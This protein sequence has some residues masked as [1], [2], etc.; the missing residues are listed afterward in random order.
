M[1]MKRIF[2]ILFLSCLILSNYKLYT[3]ERSGSL[4]HY[5]TAEEKSRKHEIG[6][7]F[8]PTLPPDAPVRNV[9]E[10]E[11][12]QSVLVRYPFGLPISM[13]K[14]MAEDCIV[15]TIVLNQSQENTVRAQYQAAG[16][17]MS[18]CE[19]LWAP[20]D[21]YWTR[22]YGPWYVVNGNNEVGVTN[23]PYN[24][25]RPD[26]DDIPIRI[27][28]YLD[29]ELYGMELIGA[30]GNY[31][32]DGMGIAAST[33]LVVEENPS[34]TV[35]Q[36]ETRVNY[37]LGVH[38]YHILPDP[39]GEYIK[40]I[41]CWG[42]FLDIDKVLIGQVSKNDNRYAD[43][44]YVADYFAQQISS[45]GTP[46]Q[47][48][49][50]YTPGNYPFTPYTNSLILN[51]KVFVPITGSQHDNNALLAYENSMP[52][53]EI[54]GVSYSGWE[55][56]DALHCRAK[57][58]ADI[59]MLYIRHIPLHGYIHQ[60]DP[61]ELTAEIIPYS[62]AVVYPDSLKIYYSVNG[63]NY[64]STPLFHSYDYTYTGNIPVQ[65]VGSEIEYYLHAA[66]ESGRSMDNPYIGA[67]DPHVFNVL[68][69]LPDVTVYPDTLLFTDFQSCIDGLQA[70]V[71][72]ESDSNVYV[73]YI[74]NSGWEPFMWEI[75]PWNITLPHLLIPGDSIILNVIVGIPTDKLTDYLQDTL[76]VATEAKT[77]RVLLMVDSML[78]V[79]LGDKLV[80]NDNNISLNIYPNPVKTNANID[81]YL[82]QQEKTSICIYDIKGRKVANLIDNVLPAGNHSIRWDMQSVD[83]KIS[84]G[85]HF[86][87]IIQGDRS[88][89]RKI[90]ILN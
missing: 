90:A 13:I 57:G 70:V 88:V 34:L 5:M 65:P 30:G 33:D 18:N 44:E 87:R 11:H 79:G 78:V 50:V 62:T 41:D 64:T 6:R 83:S 43:F 77:H 36:I 26:D 67:A 19:F 69:A 45:Y 76:F 31:M 86:V 20:S 22:D 54:I 59:G 82:P 42:K 60:L 35:A 74:N 89:T 55:N 58:V 17:N 66:D 23:F 53:Y 63:G 27:A 56:T 72:N 52:G 24:R 73:N 3:Q 28:E 47:V 51:K 39:L 68:Y 75:I 25:P 38:T 10:F 85:I 46:Y 16:V 7:D 9:A 71:K 12:M 61:F 80:F 29:V 40:H 1:N 14:E 84:K 15:L 32:C 49:R 21:S 2:T 81:F 4:P 48:Y 37:Y 8:Y